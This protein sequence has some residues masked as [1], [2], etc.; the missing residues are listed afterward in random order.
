MQMPGS[1]SDADLGAMVVAMPSDVLQ[2]PRAV[3]RL[4]DAQFAA[5]VAA[6]PWMKKHYP[7][8]RARLDAQKELRK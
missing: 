2:F 3:A 5:A 1:L 8:V 4:D 7:H 6:E